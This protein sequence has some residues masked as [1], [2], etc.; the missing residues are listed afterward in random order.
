MLN[1]F[2][3]SNKS[4]NQE[5][6]TYERMLYCSYVLSGLAALA[7]LIKGTFISHVSALPLDFGSHIYN[8]IICH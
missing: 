1:R 2:I 8:L 7:D 6:K 4:G 5:I 3:F